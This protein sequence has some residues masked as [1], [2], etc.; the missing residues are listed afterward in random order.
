MLRLTGS[1]AEDARLQ[2][3]DVISMAGNEAVATPQ[4]FNDRI[5][6]MKGEGRGYAQLVVQNKNGVVRFVNLALK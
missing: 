6:A 3:G 5:E 1:A 4:D 2:P